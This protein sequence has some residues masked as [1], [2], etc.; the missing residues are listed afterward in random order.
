MFKI[1]NSKYESIIGALGNIIEW[2]N[3]SLVMPLIIILRQQFCPENFNIEG[4]IIAMGLFSRPFGAIVFGPIGDKFGRQI[5]IS[6][7]VLLMAIPTV[8]IGLLPSYNTIGIA[9]PIIL[10][11]CRILQGISMGGEYTTIMIH[12]VEKAPAHRRGFY[13]SWTDAGNQLG[14]VLANFIA[15]WIFSCIN[16]EEEISYIWRIPFLLGILLVPFAFLIPHQEPKHK[17]KDSTASLLIKYKKE[18]FR[19]ISITS[20]SAVAFY[21]M[22]SFIPYYLVYWH[23]LSLKESTFCATSAALISIISILGGGYLS[24]TFKRKPFLI[25]GIIGV[26]FVEIVMFTFQIKSFYFWLSLELFYG[27][28]IGLYYSS[29]AAFFAEAFPPHIRCTA[30]SLSL[31]IAQAI[32]G[33]LTPIMMIYLNRFY[34]DYLI[35]PILIVSAAALIALHLLKDKAEGKL[36]KF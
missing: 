27:F 14:L 31:S 17:S 32:F 1:N 22:W 6:I 18:V 20:F 5:S 29:R 12:V 11:I 7:S 34:N 33:G 10:I 9:A 26:V 19:T 16:I 25:I 24:D 3:F 21:T 23:L 36:S 28:F 4:L 30:V 35:V 2:Y 15:I 8:I 13:G